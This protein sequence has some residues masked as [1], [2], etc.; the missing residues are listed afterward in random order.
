MRILAAGLT[1]ELPE[2]DM[3]SLFRYAGAVAG[4][5]RQAFEG[6]THP[7]LPHHVAILPV[8]PLPFALRQLTHV[9]AQQPLLRGLGE[10]P[11]AGPHPLP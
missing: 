10:P 5:L 7:L 11:Q 8:H 6:P 1:S 2:G 4:Q 3:S 9:R